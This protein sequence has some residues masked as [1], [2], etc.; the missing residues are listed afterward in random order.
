MGGLHKSIALGCMALLAVT[1]GIVSA[2]DEDKPLVLEPTSQWHMEYADDSC[3]LLRMFGEGEDQTVFFIER[4]EPGDSFFMLV[5]AEELR[6]PS[7]TIGLTRQSVRRRV[8]PVFRF[9]P[10]GYE[11]DDTSQEGTFGELPA[12]MV[13]GMRLVASPD[14]DAEDE[15]D[16]FDPVED[17]QDTD[18]FGQDVSAAQEA[19]IS[20]LEFK[21]G[22]SQPIRLALGSMGAPMAAMRKCT[23]ELLTH[24]GI[25]LEAHR[26]LTR[27]VAPKSDPGEWIRTGDYPSHLMFQGEQGLVQFRLS[28]GADGA[29]TQCHIQTSTRPKGFDKAVCDA[30]MRRARFE[31]ALDADGQPIASYY[32]GGVRFQI[33]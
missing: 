25:D 14:A 2:D 29:P 5:A 22:S 27:A 9:G 19:A 23:D 31:P 30:L 8:D 13:N 11:H 10:H 33:P 32:R 12:A 6:G 21:Q 17:A 16:A 24:W 26:G 28:V 7:A 20:W 3:R 18:I 4:Y 15:E 1:P